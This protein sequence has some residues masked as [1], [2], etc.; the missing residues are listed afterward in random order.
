MNTDIP[1]RIKQCQGTLTRFEAPVF[2]HVSWQCLPGTAVLI[3]H[4]PPSGP[5]LTVVAVLCNPECRVHSSI[6]EQL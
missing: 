6:K 3:A 1:T 4:H 2:V 5:A